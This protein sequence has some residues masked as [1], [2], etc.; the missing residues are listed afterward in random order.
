MVWI[1]FG[2]AAG[3]KQKD[4]FWP[5]VAVWKLN[6]NLLSNT[7]FANNEPK[8]IYSCNQIFALNLGETLESIG[9]LAEENKGPDGDGAD[10][11]AGRSSPERVV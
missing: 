3:S 9:R 2:L 4:G 7:G 8:S 11:V 5:S 1:F 6:W 10:V